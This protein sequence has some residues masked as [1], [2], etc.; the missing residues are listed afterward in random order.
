[1][2][3]TQG[4][5]AGEILRLEGHR[6]WVQS[7]AFSPDG[8]YALSGSGQPPAADKPVS[9]YTVRYWDLKTGREERC[10][11]GHSDR[12]TG[13]V[14]APEGRRAVTG[15][16][17]GTVRLWDLETGKELKRLRGHGDRVR[18]VAI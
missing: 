8:R 10:L 15:S 5:R 3:T 7:V 17:D 2:A 14:I 18:S 4:S 9:D 13:V 16:Y 1:M 6:S 11:T 12:V